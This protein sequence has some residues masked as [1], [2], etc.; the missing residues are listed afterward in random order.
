M[1]SLLYYSVKND[2]DIQMCYKIFL[3]PGRKRANIL[4]I[5]SKYMVIPCYK[6]LF[7]PRSHT[8]NKIKIKIKCYCLDCTYLVTHKNEVV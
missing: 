2:C 6:V 7:L 4:S 8:Q 1:E 3:L 5:K